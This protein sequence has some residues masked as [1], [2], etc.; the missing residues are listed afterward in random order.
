M[1]RFSMSDNRPK[2]L[3]LISLILGVVGLGAWCLPIC[4]LPFA[5]AGLVLGIL[6][7]RSEG[8]LMAIIGIVLNGLALI[9]TLANAAYGFHM[10]A[11]GQHPLFRQP[12]PHVDGAVIAVDAG[13]ADGS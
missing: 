8:R 1:A 11:T 9:A 13:P 6:G 2:A 4:G 7:L 12:A 10:F 3:A 5:I